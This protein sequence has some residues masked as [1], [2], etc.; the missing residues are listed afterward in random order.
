VIRIGDFNAR[1]ISVQQRRVG[2]VLLSP[3]APLAGADAAAG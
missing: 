2:Q 3:A 1:V